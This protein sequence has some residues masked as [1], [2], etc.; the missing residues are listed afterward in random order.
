LRVRKAGTQDK[1][2]GFLFVVT[3]FLIL[4]YIL[5]SISVWVKSIETAE[6]GYSEL[7]KESNVELAMDQITPAKIASVSSMVLN[8]GLFVLNNYSIDHPVKADV[9][10]G[11]YY[12]NASFAQWLVNGSPDPANFEDGTAP[13]DTNSSIT[14]WM[15]SLNN[16]MSAIGVYVDG[17]KI[18]DFTI[19]Q[20][21]AGNLSYSYKMELSMRDVSGATSVS[22][23]YTVSGRVNITG[24]PDPAIARA[25]KGPYQIAGRRFYFLTD[26]T[27]PGDLSPRPFF[28][29]GQGQGWFY[30]YL[31][32]VA[33]APSVNEFERRNYALVGSYNEI[34]GYSDR[35]SFGAYVVTSPI[36]YTGDCYVKDENG[37]IIA[38]PFPNE[39]DTFNPVLYVGSGCTPTRGSET[40]GTPFIVAPDFSVSLAPYCPDPQNGSLDRRCALFVTASETLDSNV[41]AK[42]NPTQPVYDIEAVRDYALCGYYMGDANAP[43]YMHRLMNDSYK[44]HDAYGISTFLIGT[45]VNESIGDSYNRLDYGVFNKQDGFAIRGLPG[46]KDFNMCSDSPET[47]I[48]R[49]GTEAIN[50]Y[51]LGALS[52]QSGPRCN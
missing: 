42:N 24:L 28:P 10:G 32:S 16:S 44:Y 45:Y 2:K 50:A 6:R 23:N 34:T 49:L 12:V 52:C 29:P 51:G 37:T 4:T 27:R 18:H 33:D 41:L 17:F 7:Y 38:G 1:R 20:S 31:T 19:S 25:S 36:H 22:R 9:G 39:A 5:L 43:S 11:Y 48:F 26:F 13:S 21:D 47:G 30:G 40:T 3:I 46:C 14:A 8:R 35:T 15:S